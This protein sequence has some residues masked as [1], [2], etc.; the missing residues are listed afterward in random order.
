MADFDFSLLSAL[1]VEDNR[2]MRSMLRTVLR[3]LGVGNVTVAEEGGKAIEILRNLKDDPQAAGVSTIDIVE[4][5]GK[6]YT[7]NSL[8]ARL[9]TLVNR[10][11]QFVL[12][13]TYFG[14]DRRRLKGKAP[15]KE[16]R[17]ITKDEIEVIYDDT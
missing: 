3:A 16:R 11:R 7:I 10:P 6:P 14:P 4:F 8:L 12:T 1:V 13:D 2:Y 9:T 15:G 17:T 5:V